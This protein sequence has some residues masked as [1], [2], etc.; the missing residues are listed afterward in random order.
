M[1]EFILTFSLTSSQQN[2]FVLE[3]RVSMQMGRQPIQ[4]DK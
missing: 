4:S 2:Y 1:G 3:N